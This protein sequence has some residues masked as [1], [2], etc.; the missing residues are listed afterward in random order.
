MS[1]YTVIITAVVAAAALGAWLRWAARP[2]ITSYRI[3]MEAGSMLGAR[4]TDDEPWAPW[5]KRAAE[6]LAAWLMP[7]RT[8]RQIR[9]QKRNITLLIRTLA[10]AA[11]EGDAA[12]L[13]ERERTHGDVQV[14]IAPWRAATLIREHEKDAAALVTALAAACQ[15]TRALRKRLGGAEPVK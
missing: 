8:A 9:S 7:G 12:R 13:F 14:W 10:S 2:V 15:R 4:F 6:S 1:T 11:G 3:G 5:R